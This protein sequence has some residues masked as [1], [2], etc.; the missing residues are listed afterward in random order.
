MKIISLS[1]KKFKSLTPLILPKEVIYTESK[2]YEYRYKGE[3]KIVKSLLR[4]QGQDFGNKLYTLEMLDNNK[5]YLPNSFY[6]PDALLSVGGEV[7][8]FTIP[9]AEGI[10]LSVLLNDSKVDLSVKKF[11]LKKIGEILNQLKYIRKTTPLKD[12][13]INDL[14]TSNFIANTLN[15]EL[16][17]IDLDSVK[18]GTN[19]ANPARFLTSKSLLNEVNGKYKINND[20]KVL[21]HVIADEN[22]DLY[23]YIIVILNYLYGSNINNLSLTEFYNYM[24]YLEYIGINKQLIDYFERIVINKNNENPVDLID[25]ITDE[26]I[27]RANNRV[28]KLVRK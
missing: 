1:Q 14:N 17:V 19:S 13:Y 16:Y 26:Q 15:S 22:S 9:K 20:E 10:N 8:G 4:L 5:E 23:C 7:E 21:G 25:S 3:D 6:I 24:N 28:Y 11:F 27:Y 12:I 18:I 2:L